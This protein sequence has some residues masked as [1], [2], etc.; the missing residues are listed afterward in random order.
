MN[1][2]SLFYPVHIGS[3]I[4]ERY[5]WKYLKKLPAEEFHFVLDAGCGS[6]YHAI[7][8]AQKFHY[9]TV[10]GWDIREIIPSGDQPYNFIFVQNDLHNMLTVEYYDFAYSIDVIEHIPDNIQVMERIYICLKTG[11]FFY[12][13]IPSREQ[14]RIFPDKYFNRYL[15]ELKN[16]HIGEQYT[17]DEVTVVLSALGFQIIWERYT[18]GFCGEL[19]WEI[20][21]ITDNRPLLKRFL[22]PLLKCLALIDVYW[23]LPNGNGILVIMQKP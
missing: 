11:G 21:R 12:L 15:D 6:G 8:Y 16:E 5:F 7:K 22:T 18:F 13:H 17:L 4:R 10:T 23:P 1:L 3:Y 20:D 19:A 9:V 2:Y 14:K